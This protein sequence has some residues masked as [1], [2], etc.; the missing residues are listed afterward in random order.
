LTVEEPSML[1]LPLKM[2]EVER[3]CEAWMKAHDGS[4]V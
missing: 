1:T 3:R 2:R 4:E